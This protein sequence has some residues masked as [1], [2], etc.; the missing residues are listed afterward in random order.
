M[1]KLSGI[2]Q[3]NNINRIIDANLNRVKEGLRVCEEI[4]RFILDN[5]K[6][7]LLF[8]NLRHRIDG[9][10]GKIYPVSALLTQRNSKKDVGRFNSC[11]ELARANCKDIFWANIQRIKESLRVL[12][13]FSK[14]VDR[15]AALDFKQLRYKVYEIEKASFKEISA[16]S[17]SR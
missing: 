4:T 9:V 16:L 13:E 12:E 10:A 7:T 17:D 1:K 5:H 14:L 2:S 8:K 11:G 15:K 6:F 3:K